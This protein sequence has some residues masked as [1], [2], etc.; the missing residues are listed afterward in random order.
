MR[1]FGSVRIKR[2]IALEWP[3]LMLRTLKSALATHAVQDALFNVDEQDVILTAHWRY[4]VVTLQRFS[5]FGLL[6]TRFPWRCFLLLDE[7][8]EI[9]ERTLQDMKSEWEFLLQLEAAHAKPS[10]VWPLKQLCFTRWYCYREVMTYAEER[11]FED[12]SD[13]RDLVKAWQPQPS[14]SLGAEDTFRNLRSSEKKQ[15]GLVSP[16]QLQA[17]SMKAVNSRY[18]DGYETVGFDTAQIHSIPVN[19]TIKSS[20]FDPRR[21]TG[22]DTGLPGF[23]TLVRATTTSAHY[24]TRRSLNLWSTVLRLQNDL[25]STWIAELCRTGQAGF[26]PYHVFELVICKV[27]GSALLI[28][29]F[30]RPFGGARLWRA[31]VARSRCPLRASE[32]LA[33]GA[34]GYRDPWRASQGGCAAA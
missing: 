18:A 16:P 7:N 20:I 9:V 19:Q 14:S 17:V 30:F 33:I 6:Y 2:F 3:E 15:A 5:A 29:V 4:V 26:S 12:C 10:E 13:L 23:N 8:K 21:A 11:R 25:R 27:P 34:S 22:Q 28:R 1:P 32:S 24:L 31:P